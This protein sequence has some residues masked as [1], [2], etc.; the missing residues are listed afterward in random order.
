MDTVKITSELDPVLQNSLRQLIAEFAIAGIF[1]Y[2][3]DNG[4]SQLLIVLVSK[5]DVKLVES[6][7][8]IASAYINYGL[9]IHVMDELTLENNLSIG[10]PFSMAYCRKPAVLYSNA[11][12][13]GCSDAS[14]SSCKKKYRQYTDRFHHDHDLLFSESSR[15]KKYSS[16]LGTVLILNSVFEYDIFQLEQLYFG[17]K[18]NLENLHQSINRLI[19]VE[20]ELASLF[21]RKN[22]N[23]F[24]LID[25]LE[26]A[27]Q[28]AE[29]DDD[30]YFNDDLVNALIECESKLYHLVSKRFSELKKSIKTILPEHSFKLMDYAVDEDEQTKIISQ[31]LRIKPVEEV[32]LFDKRIAY[33]KSVY[34]LLL[35][36]E[37][38]GSVV[39]SSMRQSVTAKLGENVEVVIIGHSRIWIQKNLFQHQA[40]L[41]EIM[42][43][44]NRVHQS[45]VYPQIHWE[46]PHVK[47]YP[48]LEYYFRSA[49]VLYESYLALRKNGKKNSE[50]AELLFNHTLMRVFR[51]LVF[52]KSSYLPNYATPFILWKLIV[53]FEPELEK[54]EFLFDKYNKKNFFGFIKHRLQFNHDFARTSKKDLKLM[55]EILG[56][57]V[58]NL[59]QSVNSALSTS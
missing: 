47:C 50:G 57:L 11:D 59:T 30:D 23:E 55:D 21:V 3:T 17:R 43:P 53:Y 35:V 29:E 15:M 8:W 40:F 27:V 28:C 20:P 14:W 9:F 54:M 31:I 48:D 4:I 6:K 33:V 44:E 13:I 24:F 16:Q 51:T 32:Y 56:L 37:G 12:G 42:Q 41:K 22:E 38:L 5:L 52:S 58:D 2:P 26:R 25:E 19:L 45:A 18:L 36:G 1:Y 34:Y 46:D 39:L 7:K 10:N 49:K